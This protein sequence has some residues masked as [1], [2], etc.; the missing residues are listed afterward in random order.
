MP[1]TQISLIRKHTEGL[2]P[3]RALFVPF[4]LGRPFGAPNEPDFQ[5]RVLLD[6][7]KL[8]ERNDGP[9]IE[10][11]PDTPPGPP[12]D[13]E[14]WTCP[15]NLARPQ[16]DLS[17]AEKL[18]LDL[19]QESAL[20]RPWYEESVKNFNGRRLDGL[21]DYSQNEIID[22]LVKFADDPSIESF[23]KG[24]PIGRALKLSA[25]DLKHF[26]FQAAMARPGNISDIQ[27]GDWFYGETLAG[28]LFIKI[29]ELC[30]GH[31]T[32][33]LQMIGRTNFVPN[34]MLKHA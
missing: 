11:F 14:G 32:E 22:F 24:Q 31:E 19:K 10:D 29:R 13:M 17:D 8:L 27:L 18:T 4:E 26:Y 20:L 3:P 33:A 30:L 28:K 25:D 6:A 1:T 21:T 7:L 2:R 23:M 5:R 12:A 9:L 15:V 16:T 34:A